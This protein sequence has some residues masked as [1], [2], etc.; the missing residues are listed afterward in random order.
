MH[1]FLQARS[2]TWD[3]SWDARAK[4]AGL[5]R[6]GL[7]TLASIVEA[8]AGVPGDRPLI[9]AVYRNRLRLKMP[10][11]ADPTIQYGY[12]V[13]SGERK[14]ELYNK[15]YLLDSPW[16]T[17]RHPGLPPGPIG[18]PSNEAIEAV[19]DPAKVGYLYFV[20]GADGKSV[21]ASTYA[22]HLR[23]IRRIRGGG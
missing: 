12:E 3:S 23:N 6:R 16:N 4:S 7:M 11:Q 9:A 22:E 20:A 10:L 2:D 1:R 19:L 18:N 17:Y 13:R 15:D 5:D 21:F 14:G 8:E